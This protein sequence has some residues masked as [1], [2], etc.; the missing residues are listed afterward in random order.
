LIAV[1]GTIAVTL[2]VAVLSSPVAQALPGM[3]YD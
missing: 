2:V 3:T 1:V